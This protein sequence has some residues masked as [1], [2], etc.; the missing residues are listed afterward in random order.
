MRQEL[1]RRQFIQAAGLFSLAAVGL[2]GR[3]SSPSSSACAIGFAVQSILAGMVG[4]VMV[5]ESNPEEEFAARGFR[6]QEAIALVD[7][8]QGQVFTS[9]QVQLL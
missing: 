2:S 7:L 3:H 9:G 4:V 1:S 8:Q 5:R 6:S